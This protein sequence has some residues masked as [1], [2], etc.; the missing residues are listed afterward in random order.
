[1]RRFLT[2]S[3]ILLALVVSAAPTAYAQD[4]GY[5]SIA[6]AANTDVAAQANADAA[7]SGQLKAAANTPTDPAL[8]DAG[9]MFGGVMIWIM[10]LFAWLVGVAMITLNYAMYYTVITMGDYISHLS[11][12]GV[13]W[14]ILRDV[15]NIMLIFGF[16]GAGIAT[17]L[18]VE[19]FG[20]ST[21][22]LPMLLVGAVFLNF[23]L[24]I[25]EAMID[26]T[27]LFATQFYKQINGGVLPTA[28]TVGT[29]G[30]SDKIMSQLGLTTIY[31]VR[32]PQ[33]AQKVFQGSGS[34]TIGFM[35]ILLFLV[36][37]FVLFSLAFILVF[38]FVA[39]I[40]FLIVS[41]VG[42]MG[43]A[44]PGMQYRASQWWRNFL[45]QIIVAPVLMLLL[46]VAL[47]VITDAQFL[48][49]GGSKDW[50]GTTTGN[51]VGFASILLSFLVAMGLLLVV[52]IKAKAMSAAG[53]G[54]ATSGAAKLTGFATF[55]VASLAG[56]GA[57][58]SLGYGLNSRFI[59]GKAINAQSR[60]GRGLAKVSSF[61]GRNLENR[62]FDVRNAPGAKAFA[63]AVGGIPG[64]GGTGVGKVFAGGATVTAAGAINKTREAIKTGAVPFSSEWFR[65]QQK[66]YE[67]AAAEVKRKNN[68][69]GDTNSL[70]FAKTL[71]KMSA[72]ELSELREIRKGTEAFV[73]ALSPAKYA[74]LQKSDK[75]LDSEKKNIKDN[76]EIQFNAANAA[77]TL[78][79]FTTE[80]I[81]SLD[82]DTL[83]KPSVVS[84]LGPNEL[85]N[86]MR[87]GA[88]KQPQRDAIYAQLSSSEVGKEYLQDKEQ[89]GR[90]GKYWNASAV[91]ASKGTA[92]EDVRSVPEGGGTPPTP[93]VGYQRG[94][95]GV[96]LEPI[97]SGGKPR[98]S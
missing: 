62:T 75:L 97:S 87:K 9:S 63:G 51:I 13:S 41:P 81:V 82:G 8:G 69:E 4:Y 37:A 89:G 30:L 88:L 57:L 65:A 25:S 94:P 98:P 71:K 67:K 64:I 56:R 44:I 66:E 68:L 74:E 61:A 73:K 83:A 28:A 22:M 43:L 91:A 55:G 60:F 17:I 42:F 96:I 24:F 70:D 77:A 12:I 21:K 2:T 29:E 38:R 5:T 78:K 86:I 93:A 20:W 15:A 47:A 26:G 46:Y 31:D 27:N 92:G 53:A 1:M 50:L 19:R 95:G 58:G 45:D 33:R 72:D 85:D 49:F 16:L 7:T 34:W 90:R 84:A 76:W 18:N 59:Q 40:F 23:S 3:L 35:G 36:L 79:N 32:D 52:V 80:E 39:L 54:M 48:S 6:P 11:A 14:R 10:S